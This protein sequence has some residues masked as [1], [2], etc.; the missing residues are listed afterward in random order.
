VNQN[1]ED[2]LSTRRFSALGIE[3]QYD[4]LQNDEDYKHLRE[5]NEILEKLKNK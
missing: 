4:L 2:D 5:Q 1:A 3:K